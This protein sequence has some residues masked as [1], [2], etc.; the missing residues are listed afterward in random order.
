MLL[1]EVQQQDTNRKE[2]V[3]KLI[4]KFESHPNKKSFLQDLNKTDKI[5]KFSEESQKL[6]ADM[7]NTEIFELCE[8]SSNRQYPYCSLYW[9]IGIV[10]YCTCGRCLKPS[11][12]TQKPDKK[13][14]DVLSLPG[15]VI[16]K[17]HVRG[18]KHGASAR[19]QEYSEAKEM[20]QN[21]RQAHRKE[22]MGKPA[23][24]TLTFEYQAY[25]ILQ[26]TQIAKRRSRS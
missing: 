3:K 18:P 7:N 8:A 6:I 13:N 19:Q 22:V 2:M 10:V 4:Q 16:Y 25:L 9:E 24:A 5:N 15:Y 21:T 14:Y 20:L 1:S 17:N 26:S 11:Q 12:S 23:A